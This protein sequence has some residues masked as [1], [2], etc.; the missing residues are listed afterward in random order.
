[1]SEEVQDDDD[2]R[3]KFWGRR[4]EDLGQEMR[5]DGVRFVWGIMAIDPFTWHERSWGA[6]NCG[7]STAQGMIESL[8]AYFDMVYA[9]LVEDQLLDDDEGDDAEK[10]EV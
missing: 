7:L 4:L 1:M 8:K 5:A 2:D 6:K 9:D 3:V 10:A